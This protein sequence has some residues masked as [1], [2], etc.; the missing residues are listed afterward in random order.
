VKRLRERQV[1]ALGLGP[2]RIECR[3]VAINHG[4]AAL[5]PVALGK[6]AT[7]P[8]LSGRATLTFEHGRG[9]VML[10]GT[11]RCAKGASELR[12]TVNDG[13]QLRQPRSSSRLSVDLPVLLT[14]LHPDGRPRGEAIGVRT[15]DVSLTG[16]G[17]RTGAVGERGEHV[18]VELDL[19]GGPLQGAARVMRRT[20]WLT[21]V[22]FGPL[23][24]PARERLR[25]FLL[26]HQR[27]QALAV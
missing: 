15:V 19:P 9:M 10:R 22:E 6:E 3:V 7:L 27:R 16:L 23:L 2:A 25:A 24:K 13:V 26:V 17:A 4:E 11:V 8:S 18:L 12:F 21:A 1:V 5:A 20:P 14:P